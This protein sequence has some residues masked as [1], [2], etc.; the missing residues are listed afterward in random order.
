MSCSLRGYTRLMGDAADRLVDIVAARAR[1]GE[2]VEVFR[3]FGQLTMGA[4]G[5]LAFGH[6]V[7]GSCAAA[8]SCCTGMMVLHA[9]ADS[10]A[11][12]TATLQ[13]TA[14]QLLGDNPPTS[15]IPGPSCRRSRQAHSQSAPSCRALS[16]RTPTMML[17]R[18]RRRPP[19]TTPRL[20]GSARLFSQH[21]SNVML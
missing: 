17:P 7:L 14:S 5:S 8:G 2:E 9:A 13:E 11:C 12:P 16:F 3:L 21:M 1:A 20:V 18:C 10:A 15:C 6:I 19:S 4:I